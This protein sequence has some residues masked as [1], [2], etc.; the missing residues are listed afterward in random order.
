[1][2]VVTIK[3]FQT[4]DGQQFTDLRLAERVQDKIN[5]QALID[6]KDKTY[7][8]YIQIWTSGD[9]KNPEFGQLI[10]KLNSG[11]VNGDDVQPLLLRLLAKYTR[12]LNGALNFLSHSSS[13]EE[14]AAGIPLNR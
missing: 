1:M 4:S 3:A 8:D 12:E 14:G 10:T 7:D 9:V 2:A 13:F 5:A 6:F 11:K